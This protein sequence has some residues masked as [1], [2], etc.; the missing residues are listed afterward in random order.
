M[1]NPLTNPK[2]NEYAD[3]IIDTSRRY[4]PSELDIGFFQN[5]YEFDL[6]AMDE[7]LLAA[8]EELIDMVPPHGDACKPQHFADFIGDIQDSFNAWVADKAELLMPGNVD[9]HT[10]EVIRSYAELVHHLSN[11]KCLEVPSNGLYKITTNWEYLFIGAPT[12]Y[13]N[14]DAYLVNTCEHDDI[15]RSND[16]VINAVGKFIELGENNDG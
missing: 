2:Y 13:T 5:Q 3:Q 8:P 10:L 14:K 9:I 11:L 12:A 15:L 4:E 1:R 6:R 16:H 7:M